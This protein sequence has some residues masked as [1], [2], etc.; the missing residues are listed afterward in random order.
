MCCVLCYQC[1]TVHSVLYYKDFLKCYLISGIPA[2]LHIL[3][4]VQGRK[5]VMGMKVQRI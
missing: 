2:V 4:V 5:I 1:P 3:A